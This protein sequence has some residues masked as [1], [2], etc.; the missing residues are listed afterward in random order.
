MTLFQRLTAIVPR[1]LDQLVI[2]E[3]LLRHELWQEALVRVRI[4]LHELR[5]F[6]RNL[7]ELIKNLRGGV[8]ALRAEYAGAKDG[9][10]VLDDSFDEFA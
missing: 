5:L 7:G 6:A 2:L 1:A 4:E 3:H 10:A 9:G 8:V